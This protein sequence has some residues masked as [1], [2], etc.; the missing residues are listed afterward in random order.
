MIL[1]GTCR[2]APS[3]WTKPCSR[4]SAVRQPGPPTTRPG[5]APARSSRTT[6]ARRAQGPE[7]EPHPLPRACSRRRSCREQIL[8]HSARL[9]GRCAS[10]RFGTSPA[11]RRRASAALCGTGPA[12]RAAYGSTKE[13]TPR[14]A[15]SA[16]VRSGLAA[17]LR[18]FAAVRRA[19]SRSGDVGVWRRVRAWRGW[20]S[21]LGQ[22]VLGTPTT[23]VI[24][25]RIAK[26]MI[27]SVR[28]RPAVMRW[29]GARKWG[30]MPL[31]TSWC[32]RLCQRVRQPASGRRP[33]WW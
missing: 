19:L 26:L 9:R 16:A 29:H 2:P 15:W 18:T 25:S 24:R 17:A 10:L 12:A 30:G 27:F 3:T 28:W 21:A 31:N 1:R 22:A 23:P 14:P 7:P 11:G 4:S 8:T 6:H 33:A 5:A 13:V 32:R 20:L